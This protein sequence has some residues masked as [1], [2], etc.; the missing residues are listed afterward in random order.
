MRQ[1]LLRLILAIIVLLHVYNTKSLATLRNLIAL[2]VYRF[3]QR[4]SVGHWL[5]FQSMRGD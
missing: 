2:D 3:A 4:K 5:M 1:I